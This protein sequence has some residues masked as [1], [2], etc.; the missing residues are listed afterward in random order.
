MAAGEIFEREQNEN[1]R[2][3]FQHPE[4]EHRHGVGHEELQ[5]RGE[6]HGNQKTTERRQIVRKDKILVA[7]RK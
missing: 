1:K 2:G 3:N 4:R 7:G 6:H 5:H